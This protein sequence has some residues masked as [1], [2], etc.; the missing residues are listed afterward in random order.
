MKKPRT[1][2]NGNK[3]WKRVFVYYEAIASRQRSLWLCPPF[4]SPIPSTPTSLDSD[5]PL[6]PTSLQL[7][8]SFD[9]TL[10]AS[11]VTFVHY[12]QHIRSTHTSFPSIF[13]TAFDLNKG[14]M[15]CRVNI[16]HAFYQQDFETML[17][18]QLPHGVV[19]FGRT[20]PSSNSPQP[21]T[22][23][24]IFDFPHHHPTP[25]TLPTPTL[26]VSPSIRFLHIHHLCLRHIPS[27]LQPKVCTH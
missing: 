19:S 20:P 21:L 17:D 13:R 10:P 25:L 2:R 26:P 7:C 15:W 3:L 16:L 8:P 22:L 24:K 4:D 9:S 12:P 11:V 27:V 23:C 1:Q 18:T 5:F 14:P 6:T